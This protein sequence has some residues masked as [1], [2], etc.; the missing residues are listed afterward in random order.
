MYDKTLI[1][2]FLKF[3]VNFSF[4]DFNFLCEVVL[5]VSLLILST[6]DVLCYVAMFYFLFV[7]RVSYLDSRL[8]F[9]R[10]DL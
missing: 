3:V 5:F 1:N 8:I 2:N 10:N 6:R 7:T 9:V 4:H